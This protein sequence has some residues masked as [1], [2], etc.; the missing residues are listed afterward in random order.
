MHKARVARNLVGKLHALLLL[1]VA[2]ACLLAAPAIAQ[3]KSSGDATATPA[4]QALRIYKALGA[5]D[6]ESLFHLMAFTEQ[7]RAGL[8][9]AKQFALDMR[10]GYEGGF[11]TPEEKARADAI[12]KSITGIMVGEAVISGVH[13]A[14]PTSARI[15]IDGQSRTFKGSAN[16]I[17]DKGVWKLDLTFDEDGAKAMEKRSSELIGQPE[18]ATQ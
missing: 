13:A 10:T 8:T 14:V 2:A 12:L 15:T 11:K 1:V 18:N 4:S 16:L 6:F 5:Q 17:L 7:Q 9:T 3:P